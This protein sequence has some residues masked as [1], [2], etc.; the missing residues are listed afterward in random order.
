MKSYPS[1]LTYALDETIL[2]STH[3][4]CFGQEIRIYFLGVR[5]LNIY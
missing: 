2:L 5:T 1:A 3:S 4:I